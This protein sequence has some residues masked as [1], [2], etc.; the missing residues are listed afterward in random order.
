MNRP[1]HWPRDPAPQ[2]GARFRP[3]RFMLSKR[4]TP[5]FAPAP[6]RSALSWRSK[7]GRGGSRARFKAKTPLR[8]LRAGGGAAHSSLVREKPKKP[9]VRRRI[10]PPVLRQRPAAMG[11]A[12]R[13]TLRFAAAGCAKACRP[14]RW[15][16]AAWSSRRTVHRH[17]ARPCLWSFHATPQARCRLRRQ[18]RSRP[19]PWW[20]ALPASGRKPVKPSRGDAE[21]AMSPFGG[22]RPVRPCL[23]VN[24]G[25]GAAAPWA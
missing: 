12:C 8:R 16:F 10:A 4:R 23:V 22:G 9:A 11:E 21:S 25:G 17:A 20:L 3:G 13:A 2:I 1:R 19:C 5:P 14:R 24:P 18:A 15:Q 6:G 7:S